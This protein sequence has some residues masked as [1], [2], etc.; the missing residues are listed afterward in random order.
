[1]LLTVPV[2]AQKKSTLTLKWEIAHELPAD[3]G[4]LVSLGIAGPVTGTHNDMLLIGG[5][6]NFPEAMPWDGG[7]KKYYTAVYAYSLSTRKLKLFSNIQPPPF[8]C[9]CRQLQ[10]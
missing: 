5:G 4:N 1:M 3:S 9:L 8:H 7:L 10:H 2:L 6:A